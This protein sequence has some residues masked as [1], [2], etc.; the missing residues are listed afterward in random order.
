MHGE[1]GHGLNNS[2]ILVESIHLAKLENYTSITIE[3]KASLQYLSLLCEI[4]DCLSIC[5]KVIGKLFD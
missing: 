2:K 3:Q 1:M 4:V 5:R